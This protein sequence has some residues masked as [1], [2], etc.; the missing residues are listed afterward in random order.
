MTAPKF[1]DRISTFVVTFP[2]H[3]LLSEDV[4]KWIGGLHEKDLT[5]SQCMALAALHSGQILDNATYRK[6]TGLDSRVATSELQDLVARELVDQV[7]TRRWARYRLASRLDAEEAGGRVR[8]PLAPADRRAE[9]LEALGAST[10][11]RAE[12]A[13]RTGL[14]DQTVRRWLALLRK[15]GLVEATEKSTNSRNTKYRRVHRP[16]NTEQ[17]N[18]LF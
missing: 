4:I 17:V 9:I 3:S 1:E 13:D 15:E 11:S 14:T 10:A 16:T 8:R 6:A 12:L 7:G 5:E 2:N 18:G